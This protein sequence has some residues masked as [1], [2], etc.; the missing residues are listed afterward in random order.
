VG[1]LTTADL[2]DLLAFLE[3]QG[4]LQNEYT[5]IAG[6][7]ESTGLATFGDVVTK[8][9]AP[10]LEARS[11]MVEIANIEK[12]LAAWWPSE[13]SLAAEGI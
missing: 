11:R 9:G 3:F 5:A 1:E 10:A 2:A 7:L 4:A 12:E 6:L 13:P 8:G